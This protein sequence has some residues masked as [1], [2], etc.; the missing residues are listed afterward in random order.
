VKNL[1]STDVVIIGGGWTG[2]LM[3]RELGAR[4]SLNI[5]VLERG[6]PRKPGEYLAGMDE[7][8]YVSRLRM[9]QDTSR[10]TVTLRHNRN[11]RALPIRQLGSFLPGN[12][13]GGTGEHWGAIFPRLQP[14]CFLLHS[15]TLE[16]YGE[17]KFPEGHSMQDWGITYEELEPFY[18]RTERQV[19]VTGKAGNINGKK[20]DGGNIFEGSRA[21]EY[22]LPP[23]AV[24]YISARFRDA[25]KSLGYHPFP[26][27]T[28]LNSEHYTNPDGISRPGCAYCGFCERMGCMIGAKAQPTNVLL[29]VIR[30]QKNVSIRTGAAARR[31]IYDKSSGSGKAR[32][33]TYIGESGE[34]FFQPADLVILSSWTLSNTHLLMLSGI[35][36]S[37][38]PATGKGTLGKNLTHQAGANVQIFMDKPLNKFMGAGGVGI[39]FADFDGDALDQSNLPFLR[40]GVIQCLS[41]GAQPIAAFGS[42]PSSGKAAKRWGA[43]WKKS[44]IDYYDRTG[45]IA[46]SGEQI[47]YK[48]NYIDLDPTYKD[49][50]GDPLLRLTINWRE[51]ER[52]MTEFMNAKMVEIARAMG[53][54]EINPFAGYGNYDTVRYQSTHLQGGTIMAPSPD[55]GVV[56]PYLQHWQAPNLFVLGASTFPNTGSANPTST[57]LAMTYR[58]ADAIV[59]R[60]LKSPAPL[61]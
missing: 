25:A 21:G 6:G 5:V 14:D 20:I 2:L 48:E 41:I 11:G 47:P 22:P 37:Y 33:V 42:L 36:N 56:S 59:D 17:K 34:E 49:F 60:Y 18:T 39:R 23:N 9:M 19:G 53:V 51:N 16:R 40:G 58:T 7:L 35:G 38:D 30:K 26:N 8:D 52:K 28:A 55:M 32:G 1:P 4:T 3:A 12:G 31:I 43:D 13:V 10:D 46:F 24:P 45:G 61:A 50:A 44:S 54:K 27:P 29:P 57:A 15:K